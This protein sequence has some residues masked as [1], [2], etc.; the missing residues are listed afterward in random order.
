[1]RRFA[2]QPT[3]NNNKEEQAMD[4]KIMV[5]ST[6]AEFDEILRYQ[7][8]LDGATVQTAILNAI[9]IALDKED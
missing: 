6:R 7:E 8:T 3:T 1:M 4:E 9:N 5:E 2:L